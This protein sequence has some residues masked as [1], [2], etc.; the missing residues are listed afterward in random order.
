M[1]IRAITD[2]NSFE[3]LHPQWGSLIKSSST[4]DVFLTWEWF[5]AWL[6][7]YGKNAKLLILTVW[8]DNDLVGIAPFSLITQKKYGV[9]FR[10]LRT[11]SAPQCDVGGFL[12]KKDKEE[13][14]EA[15]INWLTAQK[16][17]WDLIELNQFQK[18]NPE[19]QHIL[20]QLAQNN[21]QVWEKSNKHFYI[22]YTNGWDHYCSELS[23]NFRKQIR[24][25]ERL[26]EEAGGCEVRRFGGETCTWEVI[27]TIME[28]NRHAT[29]PYIYHSKEDQELHRSL[30]QV[31]AENKWF[32]VYILYLQ[33]TPIAYEYGFLYNRRMADW[34]VGFDRRNKFS[35]SPGVFLTAQVMKTGFSENQIEIDFLRGDEGYKNDWRPL[36]REY[37][38]V[39]AMPSS[40]FLAKAVFLWMP[41]LGEKIK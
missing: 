6:N 21:F 31:M 2:F 39:K 38:H 23:K 8:E 5:Y 10:V 24:K 20:T 15:I 33:G 37:I 40:A 11:L 17:E 27:E 36:Y 13:A 34:R 9:N 18:D 16:G 26:A 22:N 29:Y 25:N 4:Q 19:T 30:I 35:F 1:L 41:I 32:E 3:K 12:V 14:I 28:I 7:S